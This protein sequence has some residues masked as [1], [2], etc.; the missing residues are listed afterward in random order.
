MIDIDTIDLSK[1]SFIEKKEDGILLKIKVKPDSSKSQMR[2]SEGAYLKV[3]VESSPEGGKA[4][5]DLI[6]TLGEYLDVEE[7]R[8]KILRGKRSGKKMIKI[9][10]DPEELSQII[11]N[12]SPS[13]R[14][15]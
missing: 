14:F 8:I 13:K 2:S 9:K 11:E 12:R 7:F 4:N 15:K 6:N 1:D 3:D 10:G 5:R